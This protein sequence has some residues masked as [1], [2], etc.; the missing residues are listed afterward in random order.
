VHTSDTVRWDCT[1]PKIVYN[2]DGAGSHAFRLANAN[3]E[4]AENHYHTW[5][6]PTLVGWNGYPAGIRDKLSGAD[7]GSAI[8]DLTD[9]RFAG[10]LQR[11][12]PSGIPFDP[13]A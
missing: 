8:F 1:H 3:D 5:Q 9:G 2:K 7:F 13:V 11:A 12:Q 6:Y 10:M 4:P